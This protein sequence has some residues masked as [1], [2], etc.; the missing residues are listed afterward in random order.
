MEENM[1]EN[2]LLRVAFMYDFDETLSPNYMQE[3]SL[4]PSLKVEAEEFFSGCNVLSK[5]KNMDGIMSY[6]YKILEYAHKINTHITRDDLKKQG[7][8]IEFFHGVEQYFDAINQ[9]ANSI[10]LHIDHYIIS[11]GLKE[12]I[13]GTK[14]AHHFRRIFASTFAYDEQGNAFWPA[15]AVNF[16]TKTQYIFRIRK[17]KLDNLYDQRE[18]NEYIAN[19]GSLLSYDRMV[20]FGD[21]F[22]DIPCMKVVKDKGGTSICVYD[23]HKEKSKKEAERIFADT[24]VNYIAPADYSQDSRLFAI[25]KDVLQKISLEHK[26]HGWETH[27]D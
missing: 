22:T 4:L 8:V 5:E 16:T 18:V 25:L 15:Q 27:E 6:M 10:G 23:P 21:G 14:I 17:D 12:M 7:H 19:K 11:S 1:K 26:L 24:R 20:Y 9:Y 3:Y 13:E 2:K